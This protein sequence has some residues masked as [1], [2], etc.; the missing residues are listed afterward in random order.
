ML[1]CLLDSCAN[2]TQLDLSS[3]DVND[4]GLDILLQHGT[5]VMDLTLGDVHVNRSWADSTCRW[6]R[7][8]L[9]DVHG[10]L[11]GLA[12]L[13]LRSVQRLGTVDNDGRLHLP[14][15]P[16]SDLVP[17]LQQ[18]VSN[19][20]ACPA[21][22]Q[23]PAARILLYTLPWWTY[24]FPYEQKP[25][26]FSALSPLGGPHLQH[27]GISMN[28]D[29]G[30]QEVQVLSRSIGSSLR[31][32]SLR[33]GVIKP[34][35]W[36]ALS[37]YLPHLKELGLMHKVE[38][39]SM[40]VTAYLRTLART[41]TLHVGPGV[42][43]D[44]TVSHLTHQL[45]GVSVQQEYPADCCDFRDM[46]GQEADWEEENREVESEDSDDDNDEELHEG[47]EEMVHSE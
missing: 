28:T 30:Q 47:E 23:Q 11:A 14:L 46:D 37:Q 33:R 27:L 22:Q 5:N 34:S 39:N 17:L 21:W 36:P 8:M 3:Q 16:S 45:Q 20:K 6:Q 7:L 4:Q 18:A 42:L 35:F 43:A 10:V 41:F 1:H 40:G 24:G 15:N 13:P 29:F 26:L 9:E 2:L 44:H 25:Q 32:L 12:Y 38:V 31:S 19:L